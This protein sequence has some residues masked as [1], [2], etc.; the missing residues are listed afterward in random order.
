M[1]CNERKPYNTGTS[2][3][4][5]YIKHS[6]GHIPMRGLGHKTLNL[7]KYPQNKDARSP[8]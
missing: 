8:L 2:D 7:L 6:C 3:I 5:L 1:N 4:I